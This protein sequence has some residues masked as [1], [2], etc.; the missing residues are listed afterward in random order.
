MDYGNVIYTAYNGSEVIKEKNGYDYAMHFF[1][2]NEQQA[3]RKIIYSPIVDY[4]LEKNLKIS[5]LL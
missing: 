5:F 3:M 4:F 2:W 1:N